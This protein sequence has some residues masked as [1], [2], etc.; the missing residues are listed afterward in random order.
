MRRNPS[1][2]QRIGEA[3]FSAFV[4]A[5]RGE[6]KDPA[7]RHVAAIAVVIARRENAEAIQPLRQ[8]IASLRS[9]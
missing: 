1:Q 4:L 3:A 8:W 2:S 5:L 9:Q 6:V 7:I